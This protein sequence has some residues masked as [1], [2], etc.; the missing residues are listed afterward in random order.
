VITP[1]ALSGTITDFVLSLLKSGNAIDACSHLAR[2]PSKGTALVTW[3][4]IPSG[5]EFPHD[6]FGTLDEYLYF[7]D[8]RQYSVVLNDGAII[9]ISYRIKRNKIVWHRLSYHPCPI[10]LDASELGDQTL[11][12][13]I[14]GMDHDSLKL[15]L[16]T[17]SA[18]R[19]DF[20][21]DEARAG[22][23]S[24][25]V[26]LNESCCRIPVRASLDL[27]N[28]VAFIF[29]NFYP[30]L[31]NSLAAIHALPSAPITT[32]ISGADLL[33]LHLHWHG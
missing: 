1:H 31:W 10:S 20:D 9:Q 23:P 25:H 13:F 11:S 29:S 15:R 8:N 32:I 4:T 14:S 6:E 18:V 7:L 19:F 27:R 2:F 26:T 30:V 24:S 33:K 5:E 16:R 21:P 3:D 22:H 17:K 12:E 28:F